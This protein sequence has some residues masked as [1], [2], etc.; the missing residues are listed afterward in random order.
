MVHI[1][2]GY[3]LHSWHDIFE[4]RHCILRSKDEIENP[5]CCVAGKY[6]YRDS[7]IYQ[8]CNVSP[9]MV[10]VEGLVGTESEDTLK[11]LSSRLSS[12]WWQPYSHTCGYFHSRV[13]ITMGWVTHCCIRRSQVTVGRISVQRPQW[14]DGSGLNIYR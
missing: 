4:Y 1:G 2:K 7:C 8:P 12:K 3:R 10:S 14:V 9:L 5:L 11:R 6:E 13:A